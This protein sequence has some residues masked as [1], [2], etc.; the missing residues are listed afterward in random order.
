SDRSCRDQDRSIGMHRQYR[1][2]LSH[3]P[4]GETRHRASLRGEWE[5]PAGKVGCIVKRA[6]RESR[7]I[8]DLPFSQSHHFCRVWGVALASGRVYFVVVLSQN[9]ARQSLLVTHHH[10]ILGIM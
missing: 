8:K 3:V 9:G 7:K 10:R 2:W 5:I 4:E 6:G 1:A